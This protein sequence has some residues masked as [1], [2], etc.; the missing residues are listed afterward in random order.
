MIGVGIKWWVRKM[1]LWVERTGRRVG[2]GLAELTAAVD[3]VGG[4]PIEIYPS[5]DSSK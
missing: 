4:D 5:N 1:K 2:W 3:A